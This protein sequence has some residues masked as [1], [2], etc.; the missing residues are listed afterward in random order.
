LLAAFRRGLREVGYVDKQNV[1]IEFFWA[2]GQYDRLPALATDLLRRQAAVITAANLPAALAA[3]AAAAASP[4]VFISGSD[5]IEAGLVAS[6]NRPGGNIT[7]VTTLAAELGPKRLELLHELVPGATVIALVVNPTNPNAGTQTRDAQATAR[8]L[9]LELRV[10]NASTERDI[11]TVFASLAQLRAGALVIG[12]DA[13]FTNQIEQFV[14]LAARHAVPAIYSIRRFALAGGLMSYEGSFTD[15][16]RLA[17][18]YTGRILKGDKPAD[19][20][21][22]QS[23]KIELVI[24]LKTA[25]TLGITFPLT[26][27][28]RADEVIE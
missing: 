11:D 21:V 4:I 1:S 18:V 20:P 2:E 19:L 9:G 5:P 24:N 17:G 28:G 15:A 12:N 7:G 14:A 27:L 26:L 22:Q 3:K 10:L 23:V 8:T 6:L 25:K 16:Y 13:F